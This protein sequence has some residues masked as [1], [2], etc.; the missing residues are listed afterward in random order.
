MGTL[1]RTDVE[2]VLSSAERLPAA[3]VWLV[4]DVLRAS[5]VMTCWFAEGG[6][7]LYPTDS[8]ESALR[9]AEALKAEGEMPLLMGEENAI[10]PRGFD[11]GNSP[12]DIT[13][14]ITARHSCAVMAT[15][16][17]TNALLRAASS[18]VPVFAAC[19]RNA[20]AA[21]DLALSKGNRVGILCSGRKGRPAWD[22]TICAG[23][24]VDKLMGYAPN[25]RLSDGAKLARLAYVKGGDFASSLASAEHAVFLEK[26]GFGGD[27]HFAAKVD[28]VR[29]VPEL[30][31]LPD[32]DGMRAVLR[33]NRA[34]GVR[35]VLAK[36]EKAAPLETVDVIDFLPPGLAESLAFRVN[37]A[38]KGH[39]KRVF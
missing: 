39:K 32:G 31:E 12:A 23:L 22:D 11:I 16:N 37:G 4:V 35:P 14:E 25:L 24:I 8:V 1:E 27:V 9:L 10:A 21:L 18:G 6:R 7:S 20:S 26:I 2:V 33:E 36:E 29:I 3:D 28:A 5:T 30:H 19:A 38:R 34:P 17:G 13:R 15:T